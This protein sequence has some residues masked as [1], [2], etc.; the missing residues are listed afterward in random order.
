MLLGLS[1]QC[2]FLNLFE[3][4]PFWK[5]FKNFPL[6]LLFS[7]FRMYAFSLIFSIY[8][9]GCSWTIFIKF[10]L[11]IILHCSF[12]CNIYYLN[13]MDFLYCCSLIFKFLFFFPISLFLFSRRVHLLYL[14]SASVKFLFISFFT[15]LLTWFVFTFVFWEFFPDNWSYD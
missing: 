15:H 9:F 10:Y 1:V 8:W 4:S 13:M 5:F 14:L 7:N 2:R 6:F 11:E 12:F 3:L